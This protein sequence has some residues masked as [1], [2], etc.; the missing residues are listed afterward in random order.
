MPG[1]FVHDFAGIYIRATQPTLLMKFCAVPESR[2]ELTGCPAR[3]KAWALRSEEPSAICLAVAHPDNCA[4]FFLAR[5][6]FADYIAGLSACASDSYRR[7]PCGGASKQDQQRFRF[8]RRLARQARLIR[9]QNRQPA[10][11]AQNPA[12]RP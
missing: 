8:P 6:P 5:I 9:R 12:I 2:L 11:P 10:I 3:H 4:A 7:S 1:L